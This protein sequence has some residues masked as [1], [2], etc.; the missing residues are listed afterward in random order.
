MSDASAKQPLR[1]N[2]NRIDHVAFLTRP[3]NFDA[4]TKRAA[5]LLGLDYDGPYDF[6]EL[7]IRICID[8][9]AG[10][11]FIAPIDPTK[12]TLQAAFIE[13]HGEGFFRLV[14]GVTDL[15]SALNHVGKSGLKAGLSVDGLVIDP[16]W[17]DRFHRIDEATIG[18]IVPGVF[19]TLGQI[20]PK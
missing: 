13:E 4:T 2:R 16:A 19:I 5:D 17:R 18:E 12:A 10:I 8:W 6:D 7:G 20:E 3:E 15:E 9:H 14:F 1:Q 11:E